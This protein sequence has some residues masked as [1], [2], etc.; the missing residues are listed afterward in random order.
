MARVEHV[1]CTQTSDNGGTKKR[2]NAQVSWG[3]AD[4]EPWQA[5]LQESKK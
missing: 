2:E 5:Y 4:G 1:N 3:A